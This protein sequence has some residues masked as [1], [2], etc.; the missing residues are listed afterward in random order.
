M[1]FDSTT[2]L[3]FYPLVLVLYHLCAS[4]LR[5]Q[6]AL[7]AVAS[8][9]FY[10]WFDWRL[11]FL[12]LT[13][14]L[15]GYGA[16]LWIHGERDERRKSR[17]L[18][19]FVALNL[20]GLGFFKYFDFFRE[21]VAASLALLGLETSWPFASILLPIGISFY[22]FQKIAYLVDVRQGKVEP[23]RDLITF[24]A[25][26]T[27][28]CQLVAGPIER[29]AHLLP[30]FQQPRRI[31]R[32][33]VEAGLWLC[34]WGLFLKVVAADTVAGYANV[35]FQPSH[36]TDGWMVIEGT[37]AFTLQIYFDFNAYSLIAKGTAHLL[38][39]DLVWNFDRP[40]F[41][42]SVQ[43]FWRRWHISLSTWLRDYLYIPLGGNR[44]GTA[45]TYLN[46]LI[47]MVL[48]GLWHGASWSFALWGLLH[49]VALCVERLYRARF[50]KVEL[51]A[52]VGWALTM[53]VVVAG[54]FLFRVT[55][56]ETAR[57]LLGSLDHFTWKPFDRAAWLAML[58]VGV[59]VFLIEWWQ[60]RA[61]DLLAPARYARV[62]YSILVSV[63]LL[64]IFARFYGS[65]Y[66][67][68]YFQF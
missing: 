22:C 47:T 53:S 19:L 2:F 35:A 40:Y 55:S 17:L 39:F 10:A 49:G 67:F 68:L 34:I 56:L 51:P 13:Y 42:T 43:E 52:A 18:A 31:T 1:Q 5:V 64:A 62:P 32:A 25:F 50:P 11:S 21:N 45:R 63:L 27:F 3:L 12:L 44:R 38:G 24:T 29:A 14:V 30:Q 37:L 6:N 58:A 16:A 54:W 33:G 26:G 57:A 28:F 23:E 9:V 60:A 65:P 4:S 48:G 66:A 20:L 36:H 59:P 41:S 8:L 7:I 46:L 15:V 61:G